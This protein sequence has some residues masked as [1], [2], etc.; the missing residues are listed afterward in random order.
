MTEYLDI[1]DVFGAHERVLRLGDL[2]GVLDQALV[3]SAVA[4]P[5][6]WFGGEDAYPSVWEKA[7]ALMHSLARN[8]GFADGNKRT[9]WL[10][11]RMFLELNG[12]PMVPVKTGEAVRFTLAVA[13]DRYADVADIAS[14]LSEFYR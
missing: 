7:A 3:E 13:Q 12:H 8:H 4:R 11:A 2:P 10:S 5:Q 9:A 6:A 1:A 14:G